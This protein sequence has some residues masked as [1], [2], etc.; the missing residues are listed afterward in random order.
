MT[1]EPRPE[2]ERTS[3]LPPRGQRTVY[4]R[5]SRPLSSASTCCPVRSPPGPGPAPA[6][7]PFL[8]PDPPLPL[9]RGQTDPEEGEGTAK[10]RV[11]LP[12]S[13]TRCCWEHVTRPSPWTHGSSRRANLAE[14]GA[15]KVPLPAPSCVRTSVLQRLRPRP[16]PLLLPQAPPSPP[17]PPA[18]ILSM[19]GVSWRS[20]QQGQR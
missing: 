16:L 3:T 4:E 13:N 20:F 15:G 19:S 6:W 9:C 1:E 5:A 11:H 7:H 17:L 2:P 14:E 8:R 10:S 12:G 18:R